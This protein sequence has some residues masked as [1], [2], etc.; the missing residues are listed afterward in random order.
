MRPSRQVWVWRAGFVLACLIHLYGLYA[1]RQAGSEVGFPYADKF[2][3]FALFG[4]VA[5]LGLRVGVRARWLLPIL[6]ANAVVSE[7]VQHYL[8]PLRS[9]DPLDSVA[10]LCGLALG[11]WLG[12][13]ALRAKR[14]PGTT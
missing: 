10:D 6:A 14:L 4:V 12:T 13:R 7:L 5:Y 2:G 11:A 8:L 9:G 1:P 3:H